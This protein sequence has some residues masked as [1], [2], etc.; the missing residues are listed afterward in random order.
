PGMLISR[1]TMSTDSRSH[2]SST[3]YPF[4]AS[5]TTQRSLSSSRSDL[6]PSTNIW[7]SSASTSRIIGL[8]SSVKLQVND[9]IWKSGKGGEGKLQRQMQTHMQWS[10]YAIDYR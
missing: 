4:L 6:R 1:M 5:P 7:W 2:S 10:R 3:S 9:E 8:V